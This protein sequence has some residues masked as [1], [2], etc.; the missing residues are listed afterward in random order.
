M[1]TQLASPSVPLPWIIQPGDDVGF[2][3]FGGLRPFLHSRGWQTLAHGPRLA[4]QP[5]LFRW[6]AKCSSTFLRFVGDED[7]ETALLWCGRPE[8][9]PCAEERLQPL[10]SGAETRDWEAFSASASSAGPVQARPALA[11]PSRPRHLGW[12]RWAISD[13]VFSR[14]VCT[15]WACRP[16]PF[17]P[18][19]LWWTHG[20]ELEGPLI[21][22]TRGNKLKPLPVPLLWRRMNVF[23][24][25]ALL[26]LGVRLAVN[27][28]LWA[29]GLCRMC[30]LGKVSR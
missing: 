28:R 3:L 6:S 2:E 12:F 21:G 8:R 29:A 10:L 30:W 11:A 22:R 24:S 7:E 20:K 1:P 26:S 15:I 9:W 27:Y 5:R 19:H 17:D 16:D 13:P 18:G 14:L 23:N 4:H 25:P